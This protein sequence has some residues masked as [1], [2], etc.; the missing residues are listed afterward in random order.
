MRNIDVGPR[1]DIDANVRKLLELTAGGDKTGMTETAI[2]KEGGDIM[3]ED[4]RRSVFQVF[5]VDPKT[6]KILIDER[7]VA[8]DAN[9][10]T[11]K[12]VAKTQ[13]AERAAD[14]LDRVDIGCAVV[15]EGFIRPKKETQKVTIEKEESKEEVPA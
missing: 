2:T 8:R 14:F 15:V 3:S 10:A 5:A 4:K 12:A 13:T 7:V 6:A 9:E 1:R 11:L